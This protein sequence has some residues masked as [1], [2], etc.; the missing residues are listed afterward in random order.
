MQTL[1]EK[2]ISEND[3]IQQYFKETL[4]LD[5]DASSYLELETIIDEH[6]KVLLN[7]ID[8]YDTYTCKH[9]YTSSQISVYLG[10]KLDLSHFD[11]VGLSIGSKVHDIGKVGIP[12]TILLKPDIFTVNERRIMDTHV[13]LGYCILS[14]LKTPWNLE[15]YAL[16]H[17]EKLDGSGYP[18]KLVSEEISQ[19]IRILSIA[20]VVESLTAERPYRRSISLTDAINYLYSEEGK[21]DTEIIKVLEGF[22]NVA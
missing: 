3:L 1:V 15:E 16:K 14:H 10:T 21:Y 19:N 2:F 20:D 13:D 22:A 4:K 5:E 6:F 9:L 11:L 17:H 7:I 18:N 12:R 8:K